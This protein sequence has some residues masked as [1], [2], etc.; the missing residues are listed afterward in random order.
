MILRSNNKLLAL[1]AILTVILCSGHAFQTIFPV[2]SYLVFPLAAM[3][4]VFEFA[5]RRHCS[6]DGPR[7]ALLIFAV[8]ILCA[9]FTSLGAGAMS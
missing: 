2:V 9:L 8:M 4:L 6:V 5:D 3:A 7:G 1:Y